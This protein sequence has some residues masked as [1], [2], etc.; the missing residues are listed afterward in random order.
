MK[1][2]GTL[3]NKKKL[4]RPTSVDP[5]TIFYIFR[6]VIK[7][8]YGKQGSKNIQPVFFRDRKI[9][10]KATG[11]TWESEISLQRKNIIK[12]LNVEI[13]SEEITDLVVEN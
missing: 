12:K 3:L 13:G 8:E 1:N 5:E 10:V 7:E 11:S 9:F 4:A 6:Q 2:I